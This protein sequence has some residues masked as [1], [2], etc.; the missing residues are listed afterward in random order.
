MKCFVEKS[1]ETVFFTNKSYYE[2][3]GHMVFT[4]FEVMINSVGLQIFYNT[5]MNLISNR[6]M[7]K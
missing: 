1:G 4:V 6:I 3:I 7:M 2:S 5:F